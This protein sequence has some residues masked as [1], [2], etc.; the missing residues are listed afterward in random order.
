LLARRTKRVFNQIGG[1]ECRRFAAMTWKERDA[2]RAKPCG[3]NQIYSL[4][5]GTVP[6][7]RATG[8]L[9]DT[10]EEFTP[11][12]LKGTGFKFVEYCGDVGSI[13]SRLA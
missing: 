4:K 12:T 8:G 6:I 3:L 13:S 11:E 2:F 9:D 10:I 1:K 7:V 5:F